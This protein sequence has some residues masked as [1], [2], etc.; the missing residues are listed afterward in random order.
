MDFTRPLISG[1]LLRRY[2]RFLAD[3]ELADGTVVT[4]HCANPGSMMGLSD[5]GL[6]VWLE[7]NNDPKRKLKYTWRLVELPNGGLAGVD[8]GVPNKVVAEALSSRKVPELAAYETVRPEQRYSANSRIDF[9]LQGDGLADCYVEVKNVHLERT[10]GLAEF[11][12]CITDRGAK[13]LGDLSNEVDRGHRAVMLYVV[14]MSTP[15]SFD[16]A[17]DID[18]A[19]AE[20]FAAATARGVEVL[21]WRCM[22]GLHR[23]MLER[24]LPYVGPF[25]HGPVSAGMTPG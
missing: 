7:P 12:D 4:A 24:P 22:L 15:E 23:I 14:Q 18:P 2:K 16:L 21:V 20:A 17:R 3:V 10:Q 19:Y 11:P 25:G 5:P 1:R 6:N 13:H 9:L 8:T